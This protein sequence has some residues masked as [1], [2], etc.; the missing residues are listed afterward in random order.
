MIRLLSPLILTAT[1]ALAVLPQ[2]T[3]KDPNKPEPTAT[4]RETTPRVHAADGKMSDQFL[5]TW[6]MIG[7]NNE[8]ALSELAVQKASN[9]EVKQFAQKMIDDHRQ[10]AQKLQAFASVSD[11]AMGEPEP[12]PATDRPTTVPP[13][14]TARAQEAS[15]AHMAGHFDHI[16]LVRELGEQCLQSSRKEL[17]QKQGAEFDR[18]YMGMAIGAHMG[19]NDALTVF[20]RHASDALKPIL[21]ESQRVVAAHLQHAKDLAKKLEG[22]ATTAARESDK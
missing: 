20:Q 8:V 12:T 7:S 5:A 22:G 1:G 11:I 9:A 4:Q 3:R 13:R 18:C 15:A 17:E 16:G 14:E 6:A 21:S 10:M 2:D 19:A